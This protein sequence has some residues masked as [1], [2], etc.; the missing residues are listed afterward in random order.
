MHNFI[1]K[2]Y[3]FLKFSKS[4]Y[5]KYFDVQIQRTLNNKNRTQK[6]VEKLIDQ[7]GKLNIFSSREKALFVGCRNIH[8]IL[9]F[10]RKNTAKATGIDLFSESKLIKVMDM[11]DLKFADNTFDLIFSSH[12]LEHSYDPQ[13]AINEFVRVAKKES[14]FVIE[15]P[16]NYKVQGADLVDFK[17]EKEILKLFSVKKIELK[18]KKTLK[19]N[20]PQNCSGTDTLSLIFKINKN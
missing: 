1:H 15:I 12:S 16:I 10:K 6:R 17:N 9:Y 11:H 20:N 3:L 13:K 19:K 8:E 4:P 2:F 14:W 18:Y 7:L 5:K